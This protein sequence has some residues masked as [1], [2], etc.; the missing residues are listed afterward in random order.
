MQDTLNGENRKSIPLFP[1]ALKENLRGCRVKL[2]DDTSIRFTTSFSWTQP[3]TTTLS[4]L[5][6]LCKM[7]GGCFC[8]PTTADIP[9]MAISLP[10]LK[11]HYL[12]RSP[13]FNLQCGQ[14]VRAYFW[15]STHLITEENFNTKLFPHVC[16]RQIGNWNALWGIGELISLFIADF[17]LKFNGDLWYAMEDNVCD[18]LKW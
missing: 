8:T 3:Q 13:W 10:I 14:I 15:V 9:N 12:T 2:L 6:N 16:P 18:G 7:A 11:S 17:M 5:S 4:W 1:R